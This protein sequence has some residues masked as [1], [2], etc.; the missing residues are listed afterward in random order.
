VVAAER[1]RRGL[2]A[3]DWEGKRATL[4]ARDADPPRGEKLARLRLACEQ[5]RAGTARFCAD[6][7]DL[8][9]WPKGG[10]HWTPKG[11]QG[12]VLTPGTNAKRSWAGARHIRAGTTAPWGW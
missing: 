2:Q 6:E 10:S 11:T 8:S 7:W 1:V 9:L 5:L 3:L 4:G 12:E